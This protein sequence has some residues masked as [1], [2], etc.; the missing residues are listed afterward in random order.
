MEQTLLRRAVFLDRDG[1]LN[2]CY[3][4]TGADGQ[5]TTR[6]PFTPGEVE[7]LHGA[8]TACDL[9][10]FIG[11]D[12][13]IV[14]NQADVPH[15]LLTEAF[16][17]ATSRHVAFAVGA[18]GF[19]SCYHRRDAGCGCRKPRPGLISMLAFERDVDLARSALIGDRATDIEAGQRAGVGLTCLVDSNNEASLFRAVDQIARWTR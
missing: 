8:R 14:S 3:P 18:Q 17:T 12:L 10:R 11:Y 5:P 9:L 19:A 13:Y 16:A 7:I 6:P 1:V 2:R 4:T 15:G